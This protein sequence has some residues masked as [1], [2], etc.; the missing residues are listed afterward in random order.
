MC[1]RLRARYRDVENHESRQRPTLDSLSRQRYSL[2]MKVG[3]IIKQLSADGWVLV[4]TKGSHRQYKHPIKSGLVTIAG[5]LADDV[6]RGTLN[7]IMK[8]AGWKE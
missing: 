1:D 7:S 8:Q 5:H 2:S 3:D 4:R 6:D